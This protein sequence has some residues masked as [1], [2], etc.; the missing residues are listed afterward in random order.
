M[1]WYWLITDLVVNNNVFELKITH[2]FHFILEQKRLFTQ[3]LNWIVEITEFTSTTFFMHFFFIH[4]CDWFIVITIKIFQYSFTYYGVDLSS[5]ILTRTMISCCNRF[6]VKSREN[7]T[8][9]KLTGI[10]AIFFSPF[11]FS[12][13]SK[14][15]KKNTVIIIN[16]LLPRDNDRIIMATIKGDRRAKSKSSS[17]NSSGDSNVNGSWLIIHSRFHLYKTRLMIGCDSSEYSCIIGT[18]SSSGDVHIYIL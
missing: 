9:G 15:Q 17:R 1:S 6:Q 18:F 14:I 10:V 16:A 7:D 8:S 12:T 2:L 13:S 5:I 4:V 3:Y 11:F